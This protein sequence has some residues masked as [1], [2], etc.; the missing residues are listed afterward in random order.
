MFN[1]FE[2]KSKSS[3]KWLG[4][5]FHRDGLGAYVEAT[6]AERLGKI[7][8]GIRE[9]ISVVDDF[10]SQMICGSLGAFDLWEASVLPALMYNSETWIDIN[11]KT[12]DIL[13]ECQRCFV[14]MLLR[15]PEST[16]KPSLLLET[17]LM[18]MK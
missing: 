15:V 13:D 10:R 17:G 12:V 16:P 6:V 8:A 18:A 4:E 5:I 14:R 3:D 2:T 11:Q 7:K 9:I 1:Y